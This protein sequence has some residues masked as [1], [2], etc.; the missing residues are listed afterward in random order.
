[1]AQ[2]AKYNKLNLPV[3]QHLEIIIVDQDSMSDEKMLFSTNFLEI[4]QDMHEI[5]DS[6]RIKLKS[7]DSVQLNY[8]TM[9][10]KMN[11][12]LLMDMQNAEAEGN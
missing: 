1:L 11:H 12:L 9:S 6:G 4:A 8:F 2:F 10:S 7:G 5:C 3:Q